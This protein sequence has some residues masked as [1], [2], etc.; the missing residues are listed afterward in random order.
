MLQRSKWKQ[1][2]K[3]GYQMGPYD[4]HATQQNTLGMLVLPNVT[5]GAKFSNGY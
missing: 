1:Q 4:H 5:A 3:V 2:H